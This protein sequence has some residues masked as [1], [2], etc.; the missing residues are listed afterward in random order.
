MEYLYI[1]EMFALK[2][3]TGNVEVS[4]GNMVFLC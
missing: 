3:K 4:D 2:K 1:P